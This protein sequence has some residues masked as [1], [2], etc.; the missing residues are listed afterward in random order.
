MQIKDHNHTHQFESQILSACWVCAGGVPR[1]QVAAAQRGGDGDCAQPAA[2][3]PR[4][5]PGVL[6]THQVPGQ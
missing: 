4:P 6:A 2:G 3:V 1:G 5:G